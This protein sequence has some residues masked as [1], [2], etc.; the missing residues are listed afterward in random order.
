LKK[1]KIQIEIDVP[2]KS[3]NVKHAFCQNGHSLIDESVKIN[4]YPSL[5]VKIKCKGQS[6]TLYLDPVYGSYKNIEKRITLRE[7]DVSE[8]FC[9]ECG[10][11]LID[12]DETC[13]TCSSPMFVIQL[14]HGSFVEGCTKKGCMF[15]KLKLVSGE[16]E[17][18]RLF[19]D[20]TLESFL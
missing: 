8:F 12:P 1:E 2:S 5:K 11:S 3:F 9:P 19:D 16:Q 7:N 10:V 17:M 15:H 14:P 4:G 6:G 20:S 13:A 18:G